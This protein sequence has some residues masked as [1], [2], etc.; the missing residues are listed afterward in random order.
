M[1]YLLPLLGAGVGGGG[2]VAIIQAILKYRLDKTQQESSDCQK[3]LTHLDN[4]LIKVEADNE[5]CQKNSDALQNEVNILRDQIDNLESYRMAA[6]IV[7]DDQGKIVEWNSTATKLLHWT[8]NEIQGMDIV[9]I[10]PPRLRKSFTE[11][12]FY[13]NQDKHKHR[14]ARIMNTYGLTKS[15]MEF[16]M[17]AKLSHW[18]SNNKL[19]FSAEITRRLTK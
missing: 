4:R 13:T 16:P 15:G 19:Y 12:F 11:A 6:V 2:I 7:T 18:E 14:S 5:E 3:L 10:I 17:F 1:E 9:T 8:S